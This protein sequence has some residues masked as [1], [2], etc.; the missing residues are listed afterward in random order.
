MP[1]R[2]LFSTIVAL[3]I[4]FSFQ[5][6]WNLEY[7]LRSRQR[8]PASSNI[9]RNVNLTTP[10]HDMDYFLALA[11]DPAT[12]AALA[13]LVVMEVVLGIDNLIFISILTDKLPAEHRDGTQQIGMGL[14]LI[15]RLRLLGTVA[16]MVRLHHAA[17]RRF[18]PRL[19]GSRPDPDRGRRVSRVEGDE[20]DPSS[21]RARRLDESGAGQDADSRRCR[22]SGRFWCSTWCSRSTA[23]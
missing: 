18:R 1:R 4:S 15:S 8:A 22:R 10:N 17:L 2:E 14:A 7:D 13:T 11:S 5:S 21:R 19:F 9:H 20:G 6:T 12:W 23:S 16:L 3:I